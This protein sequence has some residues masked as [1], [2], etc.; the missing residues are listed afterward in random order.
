M[1]DPIDPIDVLDAQVTALGDAHV[2][3][4][5]LIEKTS[6]IQSDLEQTGFD[7]YAERLGG[8]FSSLSDAAE[9]VQDLLSEVEMDRNRRRQSE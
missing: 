1:A 4:K 3:L 6:R 5:G 8:V 7:D 9:E 2:N